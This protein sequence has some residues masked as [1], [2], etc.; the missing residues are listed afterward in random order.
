MDIE[1]L[2]LETG[3]AVCDGLEP[4]PHCVEMSEPFL[5]AE[6]AQIVGAKL[7]AEEPGEL[8]ILFEE[9]VFPIGAENMMAMLDLVDHGRKFAVQPLVQPHPED[10]ADAVR[11]QTPQSDFAAALEDFVNRE[12]TFENEVAAVLDL[13]DGVEPRQVHL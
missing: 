2:S 1:A 13:G 6:V 7:V 8:L 4:F 3:E 11:R 10:L 9:A 12:V 5:Q